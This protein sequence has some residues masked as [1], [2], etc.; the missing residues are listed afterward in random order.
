VAEDAVLALVNRERTKVPNCPG[1]AMEGHLVTAARQ[2]SADMATH[3]YLEHDSPEGV[4]VSSRVTDAGYRASTIGENIAK[5]PQTAA[6]VVRAWMDDRGSRANILDCRYRHAG[7][8]LV[9]DSDRS[10]L[11]TVDFGTPGR[12]TVT[13][14]PQAGRVAG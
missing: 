13:A 5:G 8:G 2:H 12:L 4:D 7:V 9:F 6:A 1:L 11:W 14:R 10:P 3:N